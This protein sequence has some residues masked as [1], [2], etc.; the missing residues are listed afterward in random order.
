MPLD[1]LQLQDKARRDPTA[2]RDEF[3]LQH[4]RF[5]A[6][7]EVIRLKP[8]AVPDEFPQLINFLAHLAT[9]YT[10]T[11]AKLPE[12]LIQL[13]DGDHCSLLDPEVRKTV[14]ASLILLRNRD[15]VEPAT[16][17]VPS[18]PNPHCRHLPANGSLPCRTRRA[19]S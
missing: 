4:R 5:L 13:V 3:L 2:Y 12:Q 19:A 9:T 6:S 14:V 11:L 18:P 15:L 7:L 10:Q 17:L 1:I 16:T 8:S